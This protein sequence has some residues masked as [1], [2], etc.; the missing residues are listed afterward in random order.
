MEKS[1]KI[2]KDMIAEK[3]QHYEKYVKEMTPTH[4]LWVQMLKAFFVG[5][6]ICLLGQSILNFATNTLQVDKEMAGSICSLSLILLSILLRMKM[7]M[8]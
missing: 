4:N 2:K 5:G 6:I 1:S 3:K 8:P 7:Q